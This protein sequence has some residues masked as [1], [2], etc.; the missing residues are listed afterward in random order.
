MPN[1][2]IITG[3]PGIGKTTI[4]K[5]LIKDLKSLVLRGFYKEEII[6]YEICKGFRII[7]LDYNEQILAHIH[8]EGPDRIGEYGLNIEGFENLVL[9]ELNIRDEVEL[10]IIDE[11]GRIECLSKRFC[12]R[13][14][15][16]LNSN[17]PLIASLALA[18]I[19]LIKSIKQRD[20]VS[21]LHVTY[22]NRDSLWKN[23]LLEI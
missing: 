3:P 15:N 6:D 19:P 5:H 16:I 8:F 2:V 23:I 14:L 18:D 21:V 7:T 20:D 10:F 4:I 9:P 12:D 1:N 11:I 22:K 17:V 13:V